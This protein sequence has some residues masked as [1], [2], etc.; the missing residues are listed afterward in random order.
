MKNLIVQK[1][2]NAVRRLAKR[3]GH[4]NPS[5]VLYGPRGCGKTSNAPAIAEA[6]GLT[7]IVE[8]EDLAYLPRARRKLSPVGVLL[9]C[10]EPLEYSSFRKVS[11]EEAMRYVQREISVTYKQKRCTKSPQ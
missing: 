6:Y 1:S 5:I 4:E 2:I 10:E 11:F 7:K 9:I 8:G 3:L